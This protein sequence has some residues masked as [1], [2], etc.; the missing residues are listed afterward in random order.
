MNGGDT[1]LCEL[2]G[3]SKMQNLS[4]I[5]GFFVE[6]DDIIIVVRS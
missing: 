3:N 4:L 2:Y 1:K 5:F 6:F